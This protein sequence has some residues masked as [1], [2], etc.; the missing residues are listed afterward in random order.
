LINN[1][2]LYNSFMIHKNIRLCGFVFNDKN[3]RATC[4]YISKTTILKKD[5]K[6]TIFTGSSFE[7]IGKLSL[8]NSFRNY[9]FPKS[10]NKK[11]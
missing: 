1:I 4:E 5:K 8:R 6:E 7:K 3:T 11:I 9:K 10:N 2:F